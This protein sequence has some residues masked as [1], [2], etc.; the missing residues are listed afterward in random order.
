MEDFETVYRAH[1][2]TLHGYLTRLTGDQWLAE[3]LCQ[4][5]FLRFLRSHTEIRGAGSAVGAW[6]FRVATNLFRDRLRGM[7]REPTSL[8]SEPI[9]PSTRDEPEIHDTAARVSSE[10]DQLPFELREVF[11]LRAHH[12]MTYPRI[13]EVVSASERTVKQRFRQAREILAHRLAALWD[14]EENE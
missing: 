13:A 4:E 14:L 11:L 10:I 7:K 6:L 3:E 8:S 12:E 2:G 1:G 5:T 9:D